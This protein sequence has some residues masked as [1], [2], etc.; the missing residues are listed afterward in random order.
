MI[1]N[2][3]LAE[4][5]HKLHD[6]KDI[7]IYGASD[8]AKSMGYCLRGDPFDKNI[9]AFLVSDISKEESK[10]IF[11]IPV[12]S[13]TDASEDMLVII[14]TLEKYRDDIIANLKSVELNNYLCATFESTLGEEIRKEKF[15]S[16]IR[17]SEW[18]IRT[19]S[20]I[21]NQ[22]EKDKEVKI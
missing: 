10:S 4:D 11:D 3:I 21:K 2:L 8:V 18:D 6:A 16:L 7:Y 17:C 13:Y 22:F 20:E 9:K 15:F 19:L 12:I 14:A 5:L 1:Y